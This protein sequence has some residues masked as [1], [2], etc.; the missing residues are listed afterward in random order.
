MSNSTRFKLSNQGKGINYQPWI[1][2]LNYG[3][4]WNRKTYYQANH[5]YRLL[6]S[7]VDCI[8]AIVHAYLEIVEHISGCDR[9]ALKSFFDDMPFDDFYFDDEV[10]FDKYGLEI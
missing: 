5:L 3:V 9:L 7:H 8:P 10:H 1:N 6:P 4:K 2:Y